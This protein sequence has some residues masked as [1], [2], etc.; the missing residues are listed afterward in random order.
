MKKVLCLMLACLMLLSCLTACGEKTTTE[1]DNT[2]PGAGQDAAGGETGGGDAAADGTAFLLGGT[3]PL[4]GGAA[5]YGTA[6]K[7]GAE[8]A[9]EEINAMGGIQF[10]LKYEDD[11]HDPERPSTP[12]TR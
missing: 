3:G 11:Q 5:I 7:Q 9:V 12:I 2:D 6:A 1:P 8:I 4:T 10:T